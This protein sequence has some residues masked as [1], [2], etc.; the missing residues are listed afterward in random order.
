LPKKHGAS[1]KKPNSFPMD[2]FA[3]Q[4]SAGLAK[5]KRART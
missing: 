1:A 5:L 4:P 2:L 3:K